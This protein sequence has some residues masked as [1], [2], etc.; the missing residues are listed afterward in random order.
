MTGPSLV[1]DFAHATALDP[2]LTFT[3]AST[4]TYTDALGVLRTAASGVPRFTYDPITREGLGLLIEQQSTNLCLYSEA[5]ETWNGIG[6]SN[7]VT[8][9]AISAPDGTMTADLMQ[10]TAAGP[11]S[12]GRNRGITFGGDGEK[13]IAVFLRRGS[14]A[15]CTVGLYDATT[16]VFR[17]AVTVA[18]AADGVPTV[19]SAALGGSGTIFPAQ[20]AGNGWYRVAFSAASVVAANA[21]QLR[22]YVATVAAAVNGDSVYAWGAQA[23]D[24]NVPTSYIKTDAVTVTRSADTCVMTGADFATWYR[25]DEGTLVAEGHPVAQNTIGVSPVLATLVGATSSDFIEVGRSNAVFGAAQGQASVG[26]VTAGVQQTS[27]NSWNIA[28]F[29]PQAQ[30][31]RVA[32]GYKANDCRGAANGVLSQADT[33]VTLP[34]VQ[35]LSIGAR[36]AGAARWFNGPVAFVAYYPLRLTDAQLQAVTQATGSIFAALTPDDTVTNTGWSVVGAATVQAALA[37]GDADYIAATGSGNTTNVTLA[38][39]TQNVT[40][41]TVWIVIRAR[42]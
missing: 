41:D 29:V 23:E 14:G 18:W 24:L 35:Q 10:Q 22:I 32:V 3:R 42:S 37:V 1:L 5:L 26:I 21:N 8:S 12:S 25:A 15:P 33:A 28:T 39:P 9:N 36:T 6:V 19:S 31:G 13:A 7:T 38:N 27:I 30:R 34:T 40:P 2:R 16:L 20:N 4:G 17:H 11:A